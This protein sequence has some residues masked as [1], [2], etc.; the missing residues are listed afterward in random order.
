[1]V[2]LGAEGPLPAVVAPEGGLS[3]YFIVALKTTEQFRPLVEVV[4][5]VELVVA[6]PV[7]LVVL[8]SINIIFKEE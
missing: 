5:L 6:V 3:I 4:E 1:M 8:L 2:V 7:V